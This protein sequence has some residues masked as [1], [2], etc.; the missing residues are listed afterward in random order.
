MKSRELKDSFHKYVR[1]TQNDVT[2]KYGEV[3]K[4]ETMAHIAKQIHV[5][6]FHKFNGDISFLLQISKILNSIS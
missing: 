3:F 6:V 2:E 5:H 4:H 1:K